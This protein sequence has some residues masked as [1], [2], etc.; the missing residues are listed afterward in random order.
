MKADETSLNEIRYLIHEQMKVYSQILLC[1]LSHVI[2]SSHGEQQVAY[3]PFPAGDR[4]ALACSGAVVA[5]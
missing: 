1:L 3:H 5:P 2:R 4:R